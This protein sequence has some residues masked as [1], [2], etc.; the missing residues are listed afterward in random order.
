MANLKT[1]AKGALV[2]A[3]VLGASGGAFAIS[4]Y[5]PAGTVFS[6]TG[7]TSDGLS[8]ASQT[9][10]FTGNVVFGANQT[11]V[12]TN[13]TLTCG[14]TNCYSEF[15]N[16]TFSAKSSATDTGLLY[17]ATTSGGKT[18]VNLIEVL[19][20]GSNGTGS[21]THWNYSFVDLNFVL[22]SIHPWGPVSIDDVGSVGISEGTYTVKTS[23]QPTLASVAT[24]FNATTTPTGYTVPETAPLL[25]GS[26]LA[27]PEPAS[28]ALIGFGIAGLAAAR[29]RRSV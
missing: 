22:D 6:F 3:A 10:T 5:P 13:L 4:V 14:P 16:Y 1:F 28:I 26:E 20:T 17:S 24:G 18:T 29:R 23:V 2:A 27:V 25:A 9:G 21:N 12:A 7:E 15:A 8:P 11:V 19:F